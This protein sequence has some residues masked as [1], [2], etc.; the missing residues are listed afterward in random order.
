MKRN[1]EGLLSNIE[2]YK[3]AREIAAKHRLRTPDYSKMISE[4]SGKFP[5]PVVLA[6]DNGVLWLDRYYVAFQL[7]GQTDVRYVYITGDHVN[8]EI[9][10]YRAASRARGRNINLPEDVA[11]QFKRAK[12]H[13]RNAGARFWIDSEEINQNLNIKT[14]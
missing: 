7:S 13:M 12:R 3:R 9:A 1:D 10:S 8:E 14:A 6:N 11:A 2:V 5:Q 4:M